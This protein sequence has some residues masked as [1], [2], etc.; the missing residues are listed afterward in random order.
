[1]RVANRELRDHDSVSLSIP[2]GHRFD[3][4]TPIEETVS[5]AFVVQSSL[6]RLTVLLLDASSSR[7]REGW[8]RALHRHELLL[9]ISM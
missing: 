2:T 9:C 3:Y 5:L 7:R 6:I 1:M 4:T 8:I